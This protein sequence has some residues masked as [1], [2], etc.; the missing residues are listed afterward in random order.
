MKTNNVYIKVY[1]I[2]FFSE[3]LTRTQLLKTT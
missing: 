1:E 2:L 3:M